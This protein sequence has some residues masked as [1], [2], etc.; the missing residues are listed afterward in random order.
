MGRRS[1]RQ[2]Q[3]G[4]DRAR[5]RKGNAQFGTGCAECWQYRQGHGERRHEGRGNLPGSVSRARRNG[6]DELHGAAFQEES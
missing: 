4:P 6:A 2:A 3:Y 5:A 1:A